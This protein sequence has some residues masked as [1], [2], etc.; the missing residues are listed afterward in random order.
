MGLHRVFE[1]G[2]PTVR[3][4]SFTISANETD[5]DYELADW[6]NV[7]GPA[8]PDPTDRAA[9]IKEAIDLRDAFL[10]TYQNRMGGA[11]PTRDA[12]LQK[13]QD[14]F[15]ALVQEAIPFAAGELHASLELEYRDRLSKLHQVTTAI[16]SMINIDVTG[17]FKGGFQTALDPASEIDELPGAHERATVQDL[18]ANRPLMNY[19]PYLAL[20]PSSITDDP[21]ETRTAL[22]HEE[23]HLAHDRRTI[24]LYDRWNTSLSGLTFDAWLRAERDARRI[25][26]IDAALAIEAAGPRTHGFLPHTELL[27]EVEGFMAAY[28]A[29]GPK[30]RDRFFDRLSWM[31]HRWSFCDPEVQAFAM[32]KFR[33]YYD[34]T[35]RGPARQAFDEYVLNA[36]MNGDPNHRAPT[37][38]YVELVKFSEGS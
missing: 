5:V 25:S 19:D 7:E 11:D 3:Q 13:V 29:A 36:L 26:A 28:H 2:V 16:P 38:F 10:K 6:T 21:L 30:N 9:R 37:E 34:R 33:Y 31:G 35:L 27:A 17:K 4:G 18:I 1:T 8:L 20:T 24:E 23:A 15:K 14:A 12:A 32:R 22:L